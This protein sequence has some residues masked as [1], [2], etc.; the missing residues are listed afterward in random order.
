MFVFTAVSFLHP[1]SGWKQSLI[2][3]PQS[4]SQPPTQ[5]MPPSIRAHHLFTNYVVYIVVRKFIFSVAM[6]A[7]KNKVI[8]FWLIW[9]D[10]ITTD[11][12][13]HFNQH[14]YLVQCNHCTPR[15]QNTIL[16]HNFLGV[17]QHSPNFILSLRVKVWKCD[18]LPVGQDSSVDKTA[19]SQKAVREYPGRWQQ[20]CKK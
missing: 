17:L 3:T 8:W 11:T 18:K 10:R 16:F 6:V 7:V 15:M 2:S 13:P 19:S 4:C 14:F 1:G 9:F 20:F 5:P 12:V